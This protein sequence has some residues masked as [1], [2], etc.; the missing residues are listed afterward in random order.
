MCGIL[1]LEKTQHWMPALGIMFRSS[2]LH[3][4]LSVY[5]VAPRKLDG[6]ERSSRVALQSA[7][8]PWA[9]NYRSQSSTEQDETKDRGVLRKTRSHR[10]NIQGHN[11]TC[12]TEP[13]HA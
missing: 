1:Q 6:S 7:E 10:C 11:P 9:V 8:A 2:L 3:R 5:L 12:I 13:I 4:A